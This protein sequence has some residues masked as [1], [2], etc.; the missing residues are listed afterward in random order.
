MRMYWDAFTRNVARAVVWVLRPCL[1]KTPT[2][3][4]HMRDEASRI[5][6]R[7]HRGRRGS[8]DVAEEYRL[9][10][11]EGRDWVT[12][13]HKEGYSAQVR[14]YE[15]R[16]AVAMT[17]GY[18]LM[19]RRSFATTE[20]PIWL[21]TTDIFGDGLINCMGGCVQFTHTTGKNDVGP[22]EKASDDVVINY[23]ADASHIYAS[24]MLGS[25]RVHMHWTQVGRYQIRSCYSGSSLAATGSM[26]SY[27]FHGVDQRTTWFIYPEDQ[28]MFHVN[29]LAMRSDQQLLAELH[30]AIKD[31]NGQPLPKAI[32]E[33]IHLFASFE[34]AIMSVLVAAEL[35]MRDVLTQ[36][37]WQ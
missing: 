25:R 35:Q 2:R 14:T 19:A 4:S 5:L 11:R 32:V 16:R 26:A 3:R 10:I 12:D 22:D 24:T 13:K 15:L 27:F 37:T 33:L 1:G 8:P 31:G 6:S 36:R 28:P 7:T 20:G 23:P 17:A 30:S 9:A 18:L 21:W 34:Y 29:E